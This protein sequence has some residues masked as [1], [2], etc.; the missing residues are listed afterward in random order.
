MST[1]DRES[2]KIIS[3]DDHLVEP[4]KLWEERLPRKLR[5]KGPRL[6]REKVS[7]GDFRGAQFNFEFGTPDGRWADVWTY[8]KVRLPQFRIN[9]AVGF[10]RAEM[11]IV[12]M[13]YDEMR[14][15]CFKQKER[16]E[17]MDI[18]GVESSVCFPNAFVRFCGQ[19]FLEASDKEV[20]EASVYAYNDW[21]IEEW[22]QGSDGRLI[23]LC[24][25]PLWDPEL[26]AREVRRNASRG[27]RAVAFS[28][29]PAYLGLPSVHTKHWDPFFEA[30]AETGTVINMHIG[31]GSK[32]ANTSD[33]APGGV[34]NTL[35]FLN[36]VMS[37]TDW[38]LSGVFIRFPKLTICYAESQ[39]GWLPYLLQR[40]DQGWETAQSWNEVFGVI[41]EPPSSYFKTNVYACFF[42]DPHG[43]DSLD[44][45][46]V[47]RV[48][49][50]T[51][52]P[53]TDSTWPNSSA[54]VLKMLDNLPTDVVEKI[55]RGNAIE[56]LSLDAS[57]RAR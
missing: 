4:P 44:E 29:L 45:I 2:L 18:N 6:V 51:D 23:P 20:A 57:G 14:P 40:I 37:L 47:D 25:I 7:Q 24:I 33:D 53:H 42:D 17:D 35:T 10:P 36:S 21:V 12:P 1:I 38:L 32:L 55:I 31:S 28:E 48:L 41:P 27:C 43:V 13:T 8:E 30:C 46:G 22:F 15:G 39:I 26:A 52:Y 5:D 50:E 19:V 11:G 54:I 16:L 56:M 3:V 9:A 49:F 34:V